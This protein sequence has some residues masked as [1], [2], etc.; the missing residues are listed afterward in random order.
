MD[1][2][3]KSDRPAG[4]RID[5][6]P[7]I[8][9]VVVLHIE[10][11]RSVARAV[12]R[13][14]RLQGYEVVSVVSGAEAINLVEDGLIPDLILTDYHLPRDMTGDQIVTEIATR[15]EFKPPTIMLASLPGPQV[16]K[17]KSVAD[18]IF[19]KPADMHE[20]LDEIGR[21]IGTLT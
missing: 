14:L 8:D 17:V 6:G 5:P 13:I 12:A 21:L 4:P 16:E 10:D 19:A 7:R 3:A 2:L 9:R 15:L 18:R 11:D 20:V 1:E